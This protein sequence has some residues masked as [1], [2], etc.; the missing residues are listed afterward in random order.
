MTYNGKMKA[1][2]HMCNFAE[3]K[4]KENKMVNF[5]G[6]VNVKSV[7]TRYG[8]ILKVGINLNDFAKYEPN[9]KGW[10]NFDICKG[11]SGRWYAQE[12]NYKSKAE[13]T[14]QELDEVPF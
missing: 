6:G 1:F 3:K 12:N 13:P 14:A 11:K 4:R 2:I 10:I 8:E 7:T 5:M 9:E